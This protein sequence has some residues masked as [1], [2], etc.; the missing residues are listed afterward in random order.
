M[1]RSESPAERM[2]GAWITTPQSADS[3]FELM[4]ARLRAGS[5][6]DET[7]R[8]AY[9]YALSRLANKEDFSLATAA[10]A[11][12]ASGR[13]RAAGWL[14]A[15]KVDSKQFQVW[16]KTQPSP[17]AIWDRIG[18][19]QARLSFE[20]FSDISALLEAGQAD[21]LALRTSAS[22]ALN[23]AIRP[24]LEIAGNWPLD[25][26][27][28]EMEVWPKELVRDVQQRFDPRTLQSVYNAS[29]PHIAAAER[30]QRNVRRLTSAREQM[31]RFLFRD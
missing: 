25:A 31:R 6:P 12:D 30:A 16:E 28:A 29:K 27:P 8:E 26:R 4:R 23:R 17:T 1:L 18:A 3:S 19:T 20:D 11:K 7:C 2:K 14:A 10:A 21:D 24:L 15:A 5:E 9:L 13:V 22:R